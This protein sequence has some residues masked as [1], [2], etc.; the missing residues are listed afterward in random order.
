M[1][2]VDDEDDGGYDSAKTDKYSEWR[3]LRDS[4]MRI[5]VDFRKKS[6]VGVDS[7]YIYVCVSMC[8]GAVNAVCHAYF[9]MLA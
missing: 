1:G 8:M 5:A 2:G 6:Q 7:L 4:A 9:F 3:S